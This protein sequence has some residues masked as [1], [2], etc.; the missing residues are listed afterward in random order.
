MCYRY[1]TVSAETIA[2]EQKE[3]ICIVRFLYDEGF[4]HGHQLL[5]TEHECGNE[6]MKKTNFLLQIISPLGS[7][8]FCIR[9]IEDGV[10]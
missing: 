3:N 4:L 2:N 7:K 1:F 5:L 8:I 9:F 6:T 10:R